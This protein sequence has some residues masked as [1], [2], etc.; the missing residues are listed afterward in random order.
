MEHH[1]DIYLNSEEGVELR[2]NI[3]RPEEPPRDGKPRVVTT[4]K[5][6]FLVRG[7]RDRFEASPESI[8]IFPSSLSKCHLL[9]NL[10]FIQD[11]G[12]ETKE[13][14]HGETETELPFLR[15][16]EARDRH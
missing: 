9:W 14:L 5:T 3:V 7:K 1:S 15:Q 10:I 11:L 6:R 13:G 12:S 4:D 16:R 2:L 8:Y